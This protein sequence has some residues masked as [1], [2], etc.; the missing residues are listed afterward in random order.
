MFKNESRG[1]TRGP[2]GPKETGCKR[3]RT[4]EEAEKSGEGKKRNWA[5]GRRAKT[6]HAQN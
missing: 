6:I 3:V 5:R 2:H 1:G 4:K